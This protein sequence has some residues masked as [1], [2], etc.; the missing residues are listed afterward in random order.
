MLLNIAQVAQMRARADA[1]A[2]EE[3]MRQQETEAR[4][5]EEARRRARQ[6]ATLQQERALQAAAAAKNASWAGGGG[7]QKTKSLS[8]IQQEEARIE[9]EQREM[10]AAVRWV[11]EGY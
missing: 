3:V 11:I 1:M 7:A 2:L 4:Q 10:L 9:A 6:E 8:E 5:A